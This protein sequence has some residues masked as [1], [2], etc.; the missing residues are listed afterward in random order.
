M[1]GDVGRTAFHS[2]ALPP[3][4]GQ[5]V[6]IALRWASLSRSRKKSRLRFSGLGMVGSGSSSR[7]QSCVPQRLQRDLRAPLD[8]DSALVPKSILALTTWLRFIYYFV[9]YAKYRSFDFVQEKKRRACA[10]GTKHLVATRMEEEWAVIL[11]VVLVLFGGKRMR[12]LS[13]DLGEVIKGFRES[14]RDS[15]DGLL[16]DEQRVDSRR[17]DG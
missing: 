15:S 6:L 9:C 16:A 11:L 8:S 3:R 4:R 2:G 7:L 12:Y 14:V 10:Y 1:P 17:R 13:R 5:D